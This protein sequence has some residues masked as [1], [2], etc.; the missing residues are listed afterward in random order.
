MEISNNKLDNLEKNIRE[1]DDEL[2]KE[3]N[4]AVSNGQDDFANEL[5]QLHLQCTAQLRLINH[6][7]NNLEDED[8]IIC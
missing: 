1:K 4:D 3:M 2:L 7:K 8:Y 5:K 6:I